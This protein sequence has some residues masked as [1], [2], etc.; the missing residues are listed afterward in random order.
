MPRRLRPIGARIFGSG[1]VG[2]D[3]IR[4]PWTQ[5]EDISSVIRLRSKARE[6]GL[7]QG[8]D[9][10]ATLVAKLPRS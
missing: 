5:V 10:D 7:A 6:L 8:D 1:V 3:V 9:R 4:V 2:R